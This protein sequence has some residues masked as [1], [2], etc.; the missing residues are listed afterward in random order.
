MACGRNNATIAKTLFM[1]DRAV[2]KHIGAVFQKLG[3]NDES[4]VNRR[5]MA[6]LA[7]V[8]AGGVRH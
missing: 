5:V 6:V 4:E 7:Y 8:D 1:S 2:E 3:L